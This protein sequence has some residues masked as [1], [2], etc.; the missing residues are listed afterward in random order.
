M[1]KLSTLCVLALLASTYLA[2]PA[3]AQDLTKETGKVV[4]TNWDRME[5]QLSGRKDRVATWKVARDCEVKFSDKPEA[6]PNPTY[7]DLRAPMYIFFSYLTGTNIIQSVE[8][9]ELGFDPAAGGPGVQQKATITNLDSNIGQVEVDLGTGKHTFEVD[10]KS[11]LN[12]F[13]IGDKV[14]LLIETRE[15]GREVVTKITREPATAPARPR[16]P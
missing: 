10:P 16:R 1:N 11:Q 5:M 13:R 2:V 15:G 6:F 9:R 7:K 3:L 12:D 8:V 14:T 4:S